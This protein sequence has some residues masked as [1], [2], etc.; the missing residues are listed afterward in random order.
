[1]KHV[2]GFSGGIDSQA[3]YCWMAERFDV[4]DI[5]V[6]NSQAGRNEHPATVAFVKFFNDTVHPVIENI[7]IVADI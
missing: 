1:M 7:P 5:I 2:L 3:A 6:L 4:S